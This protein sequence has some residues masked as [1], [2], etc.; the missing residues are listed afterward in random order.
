MHTN[1]QRDVTHNVRK[2][3]SAP[4]ITRI[5]AN[6]AEIAASGSVDAG[7]DLS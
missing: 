2:S 5:N 1:T 3:W 7:I 4:Q 6:D